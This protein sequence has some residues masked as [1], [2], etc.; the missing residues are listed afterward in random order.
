MVANFGDLEL[1]HTTDHTMLETP[2]FK[3]NKTYWA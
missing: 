2:N 1:P 3:D